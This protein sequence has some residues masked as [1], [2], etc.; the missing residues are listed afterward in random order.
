M[1]R[2]GHRGRISAAGADQPDFDLERLETVPRL[3]LSSPQELL[4]RLHWTALLYGRVESEIAVTGGVHRG[5]DLIKCLLAGAQV[6]MVASALLKHGYGQIETILAEVV[7]WMKHGGFAS[8][9]E[10][11]GRMSQGIAGNCAKFERGG[12]LRVLGN[13]LSLK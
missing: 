6:G 1:S 3:E 2:R 13:Y 8:V 11:R 9:D 10:L 12:Y 7:A 5:A 4:L